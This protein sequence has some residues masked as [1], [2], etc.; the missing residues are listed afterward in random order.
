MACKFCGKPWSFS[1]TF[2]IT[3]ENEQICRDCYMKNNFYECPVSKKVITV[4]GFRCNSSNR[5]ED[6]DY[7]Y[8]KLR[9]GPNLMKYF[10]IGW[11]I[12]AVIAIGV[13]LCDDNST[14]S[15]DGYSDTYKNNAEYRKNVSDIAD[16]Y[17]IS[18]EEVDRK[19]KAVTGGR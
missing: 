16:V 3:T 13:S 1:G 11:L 18:E 9:K 8:K 7:Y 12:L 2:Y 14:T 10:V 4:S 19:I 6:C 5:C 17:G 15:Y